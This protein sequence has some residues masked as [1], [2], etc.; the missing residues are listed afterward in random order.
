M[1]SG[2]LLHRSNANNE[3]QYFLCH[4]VPFH[5]VVM[6]YYRRLKFVLKIG[7]LIITYYFLNSTVVKYFENLFSSFKP[8]ES[9]IQVTLNAVDTQV[10]EV[11]NRK[12][13]LVNLRKLYFYTNLFE[14]PG[15]DG[16]TALFYQKYCHII[17]RDITNSTLSCLNNGSCCQNWFI[18][19]LF[20][21][22][23]VRTLNLCPNSYLLAYA[24]LT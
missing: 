20:L 2:K 5:F 1:Q 10:F 18:L 13:S 3:I 9:S 14:S 17:G 8:S 7:E 6:L 12:I 23:N 22:R 16:R 4:V 15:P 11:I 19:V 21:F 24:I